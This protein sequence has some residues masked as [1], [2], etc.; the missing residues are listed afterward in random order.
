[1]TLSVAQAEIFFLALT[2]VMATLIHIP[3][4]GGQAIPNQVKIGLALLLTF[5]LAPLALGSNASAAALA[6]LPAFGLVLAGGREMLI[7]TLTGFSAAL[8]FGVLQMTGELMGMSTGFGSGRVL[9]P[10]FEQA[11]TVID[12]AF[13]VITTLL[14]LVLNG[15]HLVLLALQQTFVAL[16]VNS[17][18]PALS[19][20]PL[21]TITSQLLGA[22]VLLAAPVMGAALLADVTMGLLAR[23]APQIHVFFLGAPLKVGIGLLA[24]VMVLGLLLPTAT[25][26]LNAIGPHMLRLIGA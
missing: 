9:N 15:H 6:P 7:G 12:Q 20:Q 22:G 13:L 16:P 5:V 2:R 14:F 26:W 23:V 3:V 1:M 25:D 19:V 8:T 17:P 10:A 21:L 11:G 4:L 24:L 18:L